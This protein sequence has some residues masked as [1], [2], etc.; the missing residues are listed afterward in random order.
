MA[1]VSSPA[2]FAKAVHRAKDEY[3]IFPT[4]LRPNI[5]TLTPRSRDTDGHLGGHILEIYQGGETGVYYAIPRG[6][7]VEV[8]EHLTDSN[9]KTS[10]AIRA[11][12]QQRIPQDTATVVVS[13]IGHDNAFRIFEII[14]HR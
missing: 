12:S 2:G 10:E 3:R 4:V 11:S 5:Y 14:A 7:E 6:D 13:G 9:G 8:L 1:E